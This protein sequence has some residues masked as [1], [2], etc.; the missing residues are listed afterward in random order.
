MTRAGVAI[1]LAALLFVEA[2]EAHKGATSKFTYNKEV[3]P[4]FL[5]RCGGCHIDGGVAPMSLLKYEDAFPWAEALRAELVAA[6]EGDPHDFIKSAHRQIPAKELDV[7]L[8]WA[9]GGTPEGDKASAPI[10]PTFENQWAKGTPDLALQMP[11][12][13][14]MAATALD[15]SHEFIV[16]LQLAGA[17][18]LAQVDLL[19][20]NPAIV[21][22]A[23][24]V[25]RSPD[26][27]SRPLGTWVPR[28]TR[29]PIT[30]KPPLRVDPGSSIAANVLYKK[31]WKFEGVAMTDRSTIGLYFLD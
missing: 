17:R 16:D 6:N 14:D 4:I 12:A 24:L 1:L 23:T 7:V 3:Y 18:S 31:T 10:P 21:R 20:G 13:F 19:P 30:L 2:S 27:T 5:N 9:T 26:G 28:Q 29:G 15:A 22:Q 11:A 25:L 8:E